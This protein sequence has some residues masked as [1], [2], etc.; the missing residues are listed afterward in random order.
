MRLSKKLPAII[1]AVL[2]I[3]SYST[4]FAAEAE[5]PIESSFDISMHRLTL[6]IGRDQYITASGSASDVIAWESTNS[7]V[8]TVDHNGKLSGVAP[9]SAVLNVRTGEG[10]HAGCVVTVEEADVL[11]IELNQ[12]KVVG[13]VGASFKLDTVIRPSY[14]Y[15]KTLKWR[16]SNSHIA[17]VD[18]NGVV[19]LVGKGIT[20][21]SVTAASGVKRIC[22]VFSG[23]TYGSAHYRQGDPA[24]GFS[25]ET[26]KTACVTSCLAILATN[27]TNH[28]I[29]PRDIHNLRGNHDR[30]EKKYSLRAVCALP[31]NSP[32]LKE[33]DEETH[34]TR[35]VSP[36]KNG[37]AAI[38]E[39]LKLHPEGV[40]CYFTGG[41]DEAHM[42]VAIGVNADG[43]VV[44]SDPG[45]AAAKGFEVTLNNTWVGRGHGFGYG[46]LNY[47][48]AFDQV[49]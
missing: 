27:S 42:V 47:I 16:S 26:R 4:V 28:S 11:A 10:E 21:V 1:L 43:R 46:N 22:Y 12:S 13:N 15:D 9:G 34:R 7:A 44:Y 23:Y 48:L 25:P 32:Y 14:A 49:K 19:T 33:Y 18:E 39:A 40:C 20:C 29:T 31:E 38:K 24:W 37:E 5:E 41:H 17:T 8:F 45:R 35:V 2:M 30:I 3:F 36:R 6:Y